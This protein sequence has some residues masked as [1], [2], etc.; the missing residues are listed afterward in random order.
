[1]LAL[2][3]W[4]NFTFWLDFLTPRAQFYFS[5]EKRYSSLGI[6]L[7]SGELRSVTHQLRSAAGRLLYFTRQLEDSMGSL[8]TI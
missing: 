5:R 4:G 1:M 3:A 7:E 2:R 6:S 8:K